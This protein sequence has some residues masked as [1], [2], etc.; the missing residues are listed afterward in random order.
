MKRF[1]SIDWD[2]FNSASM[3]YRCTHF[4]SGNEELPESV[5]DFIWDR[6]YDFG[7]KC[8]VQIDSPAYKMF[9][10]ICRE[11][12][13]SRPVYVADSHRHIYDF[14]NIWTSF[15]PEHL[16]EV[17]NI[18]F[19]HDLYCYRTREH[20]VNC[21][22]WGNML[23]EI[24]PNTDFFWVK[25]E[26]SD[27]N[28]IEDVEAPVHHMTLSELDKKFRGNFVDSFDGLY[29]CRSSMWSPPH[30]DRLFTK[31]IRLLKSTRPDCSIYCE[32]GILTPRKYE[33]SV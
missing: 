20:R 14:I 28:V 31:G 25:R 32:E 23:K 18:D 8:S 11:F 19:H 1:L 3:T 10:K 5:Q 2:F 21:G 4:P 13:P 16:I 27:I 24:R 22:N 30:L 17:Y 9:L 29:I 26:D 33:V 15:H 12:S 7:L 6:F